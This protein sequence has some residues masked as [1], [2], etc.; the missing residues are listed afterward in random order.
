[1]TK[2]QLTQA[3]IK[4]LRVSEKLPDIFR[5][6]LMTGAELKA[7]RQALGLTLSGFGLALGYNGSKNT[8]SVAIRR[9]ESGARPIP[10]VTVQRIMALVQ[11]KG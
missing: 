11:G 7:I 10:Q 2:Q 9:F 3:Q 1:M 5:Q 4:Q 6:A 8:L